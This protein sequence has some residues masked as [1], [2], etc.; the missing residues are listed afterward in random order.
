MAIQLERHEKSIYIARWCGTV[1]ASDLFTSVTEL[2]RLAQAFGDP[3]HRVFIIDSMLTKGIEFKLDN[4]VSAL[5]LLMNVDA[6]LLVGPPAIGMV[7]M[8]RLDQ[9]T[10]RH[11]EFSRSIRDAVNRGR[12]LLEDTWGGD[13]TIELETIEWPAVGSGG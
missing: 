2:D 11:F 3:D 7:M 13:D 8:H 5:R 1:D 6:V 12:Q 9:V 4:F 10:R